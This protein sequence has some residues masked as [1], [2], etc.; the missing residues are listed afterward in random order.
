MTAQWKFFA[1]AL[2]ALG[3]TLAVSAFTAT[4]AAAGPPS[5]GSGCCKPTP[6]PC[7][8]PTPT[9]P[10]QPPKPTPPVCCGH[11][12]VIKPPTVV[13]TPPTVIVNAV[14]NASAV[15]VSSSRASSNTVIYG[16]GGGGGGGTMPGTPGMVNLN[17]EAAAP[18][19]QRTP[20]QASRTQIKTVVIRAVCIDDRL[21]PHAAS[22]VFPG[23]D[24]ADSYDGELYRCIAGSRLQITLA[25]WMGKVAF[26][27]GW[28]MECAKG[29][30]L[31]YGRSGELACK[32][33]KPARDCNERSLLRRYGVGV[34]VIK[35]IRTETYT[36][37]REET[38]TSTATTSGAIVF[39]G[40]VGGI[41]Y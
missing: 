11:G 30:A 16:G 39:D 33:Q 6:P 35:L 24:V 3:L 31:W 13:I 15:A 2:A 8:K 5:G 27:G 23:Q 1:P 26:D 22:Q 38:V 36:A 25:D 37:Y 41:Q 40:G 18:V 4:P 34:K 9:P 20:Y 14:A 10:P 32:P 21:V 19:L 28:N 12:P 29:E 17:V 7:C